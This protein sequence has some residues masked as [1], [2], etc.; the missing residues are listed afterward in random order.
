MTVES[1]MLKKT[2][3]MFLFLAVEL[4]LLFLV[5]SFLIEILQR[6]VSQEKIQ[7][8]FSG[9]YGR[10][11]LFA[12]LLGAITPF[13]SCST[14][15]FLRGLIR[16]QAD[17]GAVMVFL[18]SSPLLNPMIIGLFLITF[19]AEVTFFYFSICLCAAIMGGYILKVLGFV[20]YIKVDPAAGCNSCDANNNNKVT[21]GKNWVNAWFV[22][23]EDYKN[24]FPYILASITLGSFIYGFLPADFISKYAGESNAYAIPIAALVGIPLYLRASTV[25]ILSTVLEAKGMGVGA[26][27]ALI[28]G[29]AGASLTEV[30][31][32]KSIFRL[33]IILSFLFVVLGIA[34]SAGYLYEY[35]FIF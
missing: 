35:F 29:S 4:T 13:C 11:Y 18:F 31:L 16:I 30:I 20:N 5:V 15:P 9:P 12:G 1:E 19:G 28:I 14:I 24:V 25:I 10:G 32:L 22:A 27:I 17:F 6:S 21:T 7:Y 8:A 2:F 33:P 3:E 34:I 23:W 26:L